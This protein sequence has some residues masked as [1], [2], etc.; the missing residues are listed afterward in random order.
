[1]SGSRQND[2]IKKNG[3]S[4]IF[5]KEKNFQSDQSYSAV[6]TNHRGNIA[7]IFVH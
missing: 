2:A 3:G 7:P 5:A 1:M 4:I 6:L